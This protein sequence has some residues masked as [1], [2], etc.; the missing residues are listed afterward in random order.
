[1]PFNVELVGEV[2]FD[3]KAWGH[4]VLDPNIKT[5]IKGLVDVTRNAN[6]T[7]KIVF[8]VISGKG[9]GLIAVLHGPPGTG[10]TL[11]AE[12]VA[13]Y[14][15]RPLY[16]VG[17][18]EL[19]TDPEDLEDNLRGILSDAVLL[20]DEADVYLEQKSLH[21]LQRNSLV[22]V[23]LRV[24]EYHRGVLFL[25]TNRIQSFDEAFLSRFSIGIKYPELEKDARKAVWKK[26]FELA[27]TD[28]SKNDNTDAVQGISEGELDELSAKPFNGR[29]IKN[30][31]RTS[32][33]LALSANEPLTID[34]VNVVVQASQK[35]LDEFALTHAAA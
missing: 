35:F 9:G 10:K 26:F 30:L 8:D 11:T 1:M 19:S 16:M 28:I 2:K 27:G 13:E 32:Q 23:A 33:A 12:A 24:L 3:E 21:E 14:L 20:I 34:H 18:S 7:R 31:V 4:L 22:S 25:T 29:T 6:S 17:A 5:L 15:Q